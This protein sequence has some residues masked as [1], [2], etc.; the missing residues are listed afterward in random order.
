MLYCF[1]PTLDP[2]AV[3]QAISTVE[4]YIIN[5]KGKVIKTEKL[6]RKKLAY[7]IK[8]FKD[9]FFTSTYFELDPPKV[10]QLRRNMQL[11]DNVIRE[12]T[13]RVDK[14][15]HFPSLV[16]A[17]SRVEASSEAPPSHQAV[18]QSAPQTIS[19]GEA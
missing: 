10:K 19:K 3:D 15:E 6:G 11:N 4:S 2:D 7:E 1:K 9:G 18:A 8:K 17:G 12:M 13:I 14:H 16:G 5:L